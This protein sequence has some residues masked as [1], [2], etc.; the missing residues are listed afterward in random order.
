[1]QEAL[2]TLSVLLSEI[3]CLAQRHQSEALSRAPVEGFR[4]QLIGI[5][6]VDRQN[7]DLVRQLL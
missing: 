7:L 5:P 3:S 6:V 2:F 4:L 1:M